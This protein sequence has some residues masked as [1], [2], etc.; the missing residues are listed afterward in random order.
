M[1][2]SRLLYLLKT[3]VACPS[4]TDT[5]EE[6]GMHK[7]IHELLAGM[8]YFSGQTP[9]T[10]CCTPSPGTVTAGRRLQHW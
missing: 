5:S 6:V 3:L 1:D 9:R 10:L 4:T 7:K 8:E 2:S